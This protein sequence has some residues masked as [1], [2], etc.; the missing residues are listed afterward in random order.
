[1]T[2]SIDDRTPFQPEPVVGHRKISLLKLYNKVVELG[3]YDWVTEEKGVSFAPVKLLIK[4]QWRKMTIPYKLPPSCTNGGFQLKTHYYKYLAYV[5]YT[6]EADF[7]AYEIEKH[8]GKT[9]P[10]P[11]QLE[12]LSAKGG[13]IMT[14]PENWKHPDQYKPR[15]DPPAGHTPG[16]LSAARCTIP[17]DMF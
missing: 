1:M 12:F 13:G 15:D 14:R 4:G 16:P 8:W 6:E 3:G 5:V 9:A 7:R 2:T 11:V 10:P 17:L